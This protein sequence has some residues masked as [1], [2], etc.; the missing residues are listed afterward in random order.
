[1][2]KL[3]EA[4]SQDYLTEDK[5]KDRVKNALRF[6][7]SYEDDPSFITHDKKAGHHTIRDGFF[8]THGRT[9]QKHADDVSAD[10]HK[11][12]IKHTVVGHGRHDAPFRGG[13]SVRKSSHF[14]AHVKIHS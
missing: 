13:A 5:T 10:L 12:G 3:S 11:A 9:S 6:S 1:M 4:F 8:Y 7:G 2:I 14:Y